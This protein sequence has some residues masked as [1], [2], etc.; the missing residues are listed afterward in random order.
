[1]AIAAARCGHMA[2][3]EGSAE[4][5]API[6]ATDNTVTSSLRYDAAEADFPRL[7]AEAE[8]LSAEC[9]R[10]AAVQLYRG[11]IG[12]HAAGH[13]HLFAGWFNL[14][15]EL[16]HAGDSAGAM[17]AYQAA[18]A[19]R[20][21]FAAA[22]INYGLLLERAGDVGAALTAWVSATQADEAR[23][24]LINHRARLLERNGQLQ[25]AER[26]LLT[27]LLTLPAQP[28]VI[29]HWVHVRQKMCLWPALVEI[30][31]GLKMDQMIACCGPLAALALFER[32]DEQTAIAA[33]W[34]ARKTT[35]VA[36]RL[37]PAVGYAHTRLR[38]GYLSSD[39]C[40]HA[41]SF[42]IAELFERHDRAR[43]E[44][45]GYCSTI[46]DHSDIRARVLAAFDHTRFVRDLSD[47]AAARLIR[48]DEIDILIDLNGLTQGAR[49][50]ILR[51]RPAPVQATYL[52]FI[53]PVPLPE[54]DYLFCDDFVIPPA[55]APAYQPRP[56]AI[57]PNYQAN[58][59]KRRPGPPTTRAKAGLPATGFVFCCFSNHYKITEDMFAAW[60]EILR[61]A[62]GS[63]LWLTADDE[64]SSENL[65]R[66]AV[67]SGVDPATLIFAG[68]ASPADYM[69][70]L[71]VADLFLD[72]FPY[73][74]GTIASDAIRMGLPLLTQ[75]GESYA[76]R[77]AARLLEAIGATTGI[78][79]SRA[80]YIDSA[81]ALATDKSVYLTYR[82]LFTE[83]NWAA[84]VGNIGL[85]TRELETTLC[86][87]AKRAGK[88]AQVA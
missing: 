41:M 29:Q 11:W 76:S 60:I 1:M 57:A 81:V 18:L 30:V 66:C 7:V 63:F 54:L 74:A 87:I 31:P 65:R 56:L 44:I 13:P 19:L 47:A 55:L 2:G 40:R 79:T 82:S 38:I 85:L 4:R 26:L 72:T 22:A 78:A 67:R 58:D 5:S 51:W 61:R 9:G 32:V 46:D 83:A 20:P 68:R 43:F 33:S 80:H 21:D 17:Q 16:G 50:Q 6:S 28:D 88:D 49:L 24:S 10:A 69:A 64:W 34:I 84:T 25:Q 27:S 53:G 70:R 37:S 14:G 45:F 15:A 62:D 48:E 35:P 36:E 23:T 73:N 59:S 71:A 42:L 8:R 86:A 52:G 75:I 3:F 39:F 77:M 12:L